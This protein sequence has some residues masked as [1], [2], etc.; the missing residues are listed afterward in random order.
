MKVNHSFLSVL[1]ALVIFC[2]TII[3]REH[4]SIAISKAE[5]QQIKAAMGKYPLLDKT[6]AGYRET[7]ENALNKPI[8]LPAP[9][10]AGGYSH[11]RHK[12]NYR[13]MHR[14]GLLFAI[15]GEEKYAQFIKKMLDGYA[16]LYPTLG[17]HPR[18]FKQKPGKLF[19][20]TLNEEVW[21]THVAIAYDCV[22]ETIAPNMKQIFFLK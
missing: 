17:P 20:Q 4:P 11:E 9:G 21:L 13:E 16:E 12:Q 18:S 7:V 8:E 2:G 19:H 3:A 14:A 6:I 10:E 5:A 15:T 1:V 22:Y